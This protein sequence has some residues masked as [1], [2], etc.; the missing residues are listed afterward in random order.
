MALVKVFSRAPI[1]HLFTVADGGREIKVEIKG[2]NSH[3]I[4]TNSNGISQGDR[5]DPYLNEVDELIFAKIVDKYKSHVKLFGGEINGIKHDAMI[6]S[7]KSVSEAMKKKE[8]SAPIVQNEREIMVSKTKGV[9]PLK[10]DS[11][12]I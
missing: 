7:A 2:M 1:G 11:F 3:Q 4:I 12:G 6:Y 9:S 10:N 8:D 5:E